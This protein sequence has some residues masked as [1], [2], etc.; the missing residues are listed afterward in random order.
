MCFAGTKIYHNTLFCYYQIIKYYK[1]IAAVDVTSGPK[2]RRHFRQRC[3]D[4]QWYINRA[5]EK[6]FRR[7]FCTA[8][9]LNELKGDCCME[10]ISSRCVRQTAALFSY[11]ISIW[12][13]LLARL[14][15]QSCLKGCVVNQIWK[16]GNHIAWEYFFILWGGIS[17]ICLLPSP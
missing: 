17:C 12:R 16:C 10:R 1:N 11:S 14:Y 7:S 2:R 3:N 6:L 15:T 9:R 13:V 8:A 4:R 5:E